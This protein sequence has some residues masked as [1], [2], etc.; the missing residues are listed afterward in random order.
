MTDSGSGP[1]EGTS[2]SSLVWITFQLEAAL[3][4]L[5]LLLGSFGL[6][7]PD[8]SLIRFTWEDTVR[9]ALLWGVGGALPLIGLSVF[10]RNSRWRLFEQIRAAIAAHLLPLIRGC[11]LAGVALIALLAGLGEELLFRWSIQGGVTRLASGVWGNTAAVVTGIAAG[12][13]LFGLC[14]AVNR[15]YFL[16]ATL[17]GVWLGLVMWLSGTW[18]AAALAHALTD[19]YSLAVLAGHLEERPAGGERGKNGG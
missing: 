12:G 10:G 1:E 2:Q 4:G 18:L 16:V 13:V 8:Q 9:P 11:D 5:A 19:L 17:A 7:D 14:H 3:A 6:R 15:S